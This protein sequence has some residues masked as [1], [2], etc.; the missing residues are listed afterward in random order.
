M[1]VEQQTSVLKEFTEMAI[2][3]NS[4]VSGSV[5]Y[6]RMV[7]EK[8]VGLFKAAEVIGRVGTRRTSVAAMQQIIDLDATSMCNLLKE[9]QPQTVALVLSYLTARKSRDPIVVAHQAVT[10]R[11]WRR[12]KRFDLYCSQVVLREAKAGDEEAGRVASHVRAEAETAERRQRREGRS[13]G[14]GLWKLMWRGWGR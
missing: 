13:M 2:Q 14:A 7:L 5:E 3:A 8:S 4:G 6:T 9:E 11:W 1:T 12:R 10:Q